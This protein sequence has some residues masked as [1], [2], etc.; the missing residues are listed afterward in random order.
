MTELKSDHESIARG[1]KGYTLVLAEKPDASKRIASALGTPHSRELD[2]IGYYEVESAFNGC[3]YVVCSASGHLYGLADPHEIRGIF[4]VLDVEWFPLNLIFEAQRRNASFTRTSQRKSYLPRVAKRIRTISNLASRASSY[5]HACDVDTEGEVIGYNILKFACP[6]SSADIL[7]ARFSTLTDSEIRSAFSNLTKIDESLPKAGRMR[8]LVD[9]LWGVNVSRALTE[10]ISSSNSEYRMLSMG[11]V[12]GPALA[13]VVEREIEVNSHVP[14]PFWTLSCTLEKNGI[15][16]EA[17]YEGGRLSKLAAAE[18]I[19]D[20][21]SRTKLAYVKSSKETRRLIPPPFPFNLGDLQKEA[22]RIYKLSPSFVFAAAERLYLKAMI[23]Y[24]RTD[25]QKLPASIGYPAIFRKLCTNPLVTQLVADLIKEAG[26]N[27]S[28]KQGPLDDTAH[29]A[30]FP[31]G[32]CASI[33]LE[34]IDS[35]IFDMIARRF[36]ATFANGAITED[37]LTIFE[38]EGY[39]FLASGSALVERGG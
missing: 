38:I 30:I 32:E 25:S 23:S 14:A 17:N 28:P 21:A 1:Q 29:P 20:V 24:P 8:H 7:R 19:H 22:Y 9:F 35:M 4:P 6:K 2:G 10:S 12:Q 31:T 33:N 26:P 3:R 11:R 37:M 13:F 18:K 27:P 36:F 39:N 5:I 16:F 15:Q 34:K